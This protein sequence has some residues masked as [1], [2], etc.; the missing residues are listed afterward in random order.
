MHVPERR[1]T[2]R[3]RP[4]MVGPQLVSP[5]ARRAEDCRAIFPRRGNSCGRFLE[6]AVRTHLIARDVPVGLFLSSD[7]IRRNRGAY[8]AVAWRNQ[9]ASH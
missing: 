9:E 3:A 2:P 6:D 8:A 1:R 5:A 7:W 4:P